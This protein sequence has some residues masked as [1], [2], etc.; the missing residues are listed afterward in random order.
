[1]AGPKDDHT[2]RERVAGHGDI[3]RPATRA[4]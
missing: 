4:F 3:H 2:Q 1:V